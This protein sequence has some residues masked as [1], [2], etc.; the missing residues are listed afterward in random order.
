MATTR[1]GLPINMLRMDLKNSPEHTHPPPYVKTFA[2]VLGLLAVS[3]IL[4]TVFGWFNSVDVKGWWPVVFALEMIVSCAY[5][6]AYAFIARTGA[7][8]SLRFSIGYTLA[9]SGCILAH[10]AL[11]FLVRPDWLAVNTGVAT[12]TPFQQIVFGRYTVF[13]MYGIFLGM[14]AFRALRLRQLAG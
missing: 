12:L 3:N 10:T 11:Y 1:L 14:A 2:V 13:A 7:P 5:A 4:S 6:L 8:F 9:L